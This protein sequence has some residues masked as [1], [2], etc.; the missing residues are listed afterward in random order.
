M[1]ARE[2]LGVRGRVRHADGTNTFVPD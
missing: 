1:T 2:Y